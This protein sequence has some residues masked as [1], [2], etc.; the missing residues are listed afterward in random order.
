MPQPPFNENTGSI[1][2]EP[3]DAHAPTLVSLITQALDD[4][5]FPLSKAEI[6]SRAG[7]RR[8]RFPNGQS[9]ALF[10]LLVAVQESHFDSAAA[11]ANA[12]SH[13]MW[14]SDR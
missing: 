12:V 13:P 11:V 14:S 2:F 4:M 8:I 5:S 3:E 7:E 9:M 10:D 1:D 6:L